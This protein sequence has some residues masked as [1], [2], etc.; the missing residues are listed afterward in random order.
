MKSNPVYREQATLLQVAQPHAK[1]TVSSSSGNCRVNLRPTSPKP[2]ASSSSASL[3]SMAAVGK[4]R[5]SGLLAKTSFP[6]K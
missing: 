2:S 1:H 3:Q 5:Q 6:Y 4:T